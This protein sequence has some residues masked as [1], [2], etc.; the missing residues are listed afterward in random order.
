MTTSASD[1][2]V[3]TYR[4]VAHLGGCLASIA[5]QGDAVASVFVV[6][7]AS[8][9]GSAELAASR[10]GA[11]VVS[12]DRNIG[13]AAAANRGVAM[14]TAPTVL[15]LNPDAELDAGALRALQV[16]LAAD[17]ALAAVTGSIRRADGSPYPSARRFP[18]LLTAAAH[19]LLG[20]LV[21]GNRWSR[22]YLVT[23]DP[24]WIAGTAMLVSRAAFEAV[25][26]FDERYFMYVEDVDLCRRWR[27][28][29]FRVGV[30]A[31]AGVVHLIGGS[32]RSRPTRMVVEHHRSLWRYACS[33]RRGPGVTALPLIAVG[34]VL[35]TLLVIAV[36]A[37][38]GRAPAAH[39]RPSTS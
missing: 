13:F 23:D 28:R 6:D 26:G 8:G 30:V 3:V 37:V 20:L 25:G 38:T 2:V 24:D 17:S 27:D 29:G 5:R 22:R 39:H 33:T 10:P 32:T 14:G 34:L 9:D 21:P 31:G 36:S 19:G 18:S 4:S 35:R 15:F 11:T 12:L 7:N 1:V 16:G